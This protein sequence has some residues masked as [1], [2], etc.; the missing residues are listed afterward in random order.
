MSSI[1][2]VL[3]SLYIYKIMNSEETSSNEFDSTIL[4]L[5]SILASLFLFFTQYRG[6][7]LI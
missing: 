7:T 3:H 6:L 2:E 5:S 1:Y 4:Y